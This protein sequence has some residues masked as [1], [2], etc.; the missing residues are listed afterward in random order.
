MFQVIIAPMRKSQIMLNIF[1]PRKEKKCPLCII[2]ENTK[3]KIKHLL[4][5]GSGAIV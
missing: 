4:L 3:S 1:F 2:N 5:M